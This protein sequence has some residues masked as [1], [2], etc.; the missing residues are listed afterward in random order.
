MKKRPC[1]I[2][3]LSLVLIALSAG[4]SLAGAAVQ[5]EDATAA[6][7]LDGFEHYSYGYGGDGLAGAAWFDY[8]EDGLLDLYLTNGKDITTPGRS[9]FDNALYEN[10]GDGSFV[11]VAGLRGV[12]H[13]EGSSGVIAADIDNDGDQDIFLTGDGGVL[14][15]DGIDGSQTID[16]GVALY[17]NDGAPDYGFT[18]I[19]NAT[20]GLV[21]LESTMSAA[22]ADVDNDGLLDLFVTA[23]GTRPAGCL[24]PDCVDDATTKRHTSGLFLN[25]SSGGN[26]SFADISVP[27]TIADTRYGALAAAFTDHDDDGRIDLLV[28]NG[29]AFVF[30]P[31]PIQLYRNLGHDARIDVVT[32]DDV[33]SSVG[34]GTQA[35]WMGLALADF[36][37]NR[38]TDIFVSNS[39][40]G[41][42]QPHALYR[43]LPSGQY[44][45][46]A[47]TTGVAGPSPSPS[48]FFGWGCTAQD[49]D[50]DARADLFLAGNGVAGPG[51][52]GPTPNPG[53][54]LLWEPGV[55]FV[56]QSAAL[57]VDLTNR[58]TSGVAAADYDN[59]GRVDIAVAT[60]ALNGDQGIPILL[61]N[62]TVSDNRWVTVRLTGDGITTNRDAVGA[63]VAVI[64][65]TPPN[66]VIQVREV[67]AGSSFL[68]MDSKWQTFGLGPLN[69]AAPI[70]VAV[71]W[72]SGPQTPNDLANWTVYGPFASNGFVDIGQ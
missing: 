39:G 66:R 18:R 29:V 11:D 71:D 69:P 59:D 34:L 8:N 48:D 30:E 65:G 22:M 50:N 20:A 5:F 54:L 44:V 35:L 28:A 47:A 13:G 4:P 16:S 21:G 51:G 61:R 6:A 63:R 45:D 56:D 2:V 70:Y 72:P 60:D 41:G 43:S 58:F 26:V 3:C 42:A 68:S 36:D 67:L 1:L 12:T 49:F 57:G 37:R 32:F 62:T 55:A 33:S 53:T 7:G 15:H 10:Q 64:Y 31:T 9:G 17:V 23:P 38:R 14:G 40:T 19:D 52:G 46:V 24:P 27:S 25:R